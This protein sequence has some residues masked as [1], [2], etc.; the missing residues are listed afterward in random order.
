MY[1]YTQKHIYITFSSSICPL[2][3]AYV[4]A[5]VKSTAMNIGVQVSEL[6]IS[7]PLDTHPEVGLLD[8]VVVHF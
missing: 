3:V 4:L 8:H 1:T 2:K 7:F 6:V 5:I